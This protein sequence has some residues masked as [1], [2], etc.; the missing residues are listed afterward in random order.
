MDAQRIGGRIAR[1]LS[2]R[3]VILSLVAG[4]GAGVLIGLAWP[5]ATMPV[6]WTVAAA[7]YLL[8]IFNDAQMIRCPACRKRVKM[9]A[10]TCH[11]CGYTA[12]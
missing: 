8:A 3:V 9:G 11:H 12:T 6:V 2:I 5:A 7:C 1:A 10:D 4:V